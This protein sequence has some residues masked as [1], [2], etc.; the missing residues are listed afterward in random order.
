MR[1]RYRG[2]AAL[3]GMTTWRGS[4]TAA[5]GWGGA[6]ERMRVPEALPGSHEAFFHETGVRNFF[7]PTA[8]LQERRLQRAMGV[9]CLPQS[10]Q[11]SDYFHA[12]LAG[13]LDFV[14]HFDETRAVEP[15]E[16]IPAP[17]GE[18]PETF[19]VGV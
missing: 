16:R 17:A 6:A 2:Q 3:V 15:L 7:V 18:A 12:E 9:V 19:P 4:V 14:L 1:Q 8:G 10:E 13:Q 5:A 11:M